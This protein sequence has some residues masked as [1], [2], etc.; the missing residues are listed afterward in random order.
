M[1]LEKWRDIESVSTK[2]ISMLISIAQFHFSSK[3]FSLVKLFWFYQDDSA[4]MAVY[5]FEIQIFSTNK[6]NLSQVIFCFY[7]STIYLR[8]IQN[9]ELSYYEVNFMFIKNFC[10]LFCLS[11]F[12]LMITE[13]QENHHFCAQTYHIGLT[14]HVMKTMIFSTKMVMPNIWKQGAVVITKIT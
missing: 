11:A 1:S 4:E 14:S 8:F 9:L 13:D 2:N 5:S 3:I 10:T 6:T 7:F 12:G